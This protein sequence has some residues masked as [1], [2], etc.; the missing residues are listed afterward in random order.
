[1]EGALTDVC[2]F[3]QVEV[4]T[5]RPAIPIW[6][7]DIHCHHRADSDGVRLLI[8]IT[9]D[10]TGADDIIHCSTLFSGPIPPILNKYYSNTIAHP[11]Y[12]LAYPTAR[13]P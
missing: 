10:L 3:C 8:F 5:R 7:Y 4:G 2:T 12:I 13:L 1:M 11:L 6:L 9:E